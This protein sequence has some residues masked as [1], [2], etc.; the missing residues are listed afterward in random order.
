MNPTLKELS[1]EIESGLL[2]LPSSSIVLIPARLVGRGVEGSPGALYN[3]YFTFEPIPYFE[4]QPDADGDEHRIRIYAESL[5]HL[6]P[7]NPKLIDRSR[8]E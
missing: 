6:A 7:Y 8:F 4:F 2:R 3:S 5:C 1:H